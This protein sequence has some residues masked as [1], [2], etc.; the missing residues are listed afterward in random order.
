MWYDKNR[1]KLRYFQ[2]TGHV[3]GKVCSPTCAL[4]ATQRNAQDH[5]DRMPRAAKVVRKSTL[6]DDSLDSMTTWQEARQVILDLIEMHK[7]IGL[8]I[9]KFATNSLKLSESLPEHVQKSEELKFYEQAFGPQQMEYAP[10]TVPKMPQV[11]ALGQF[12]NLATD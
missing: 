5:A 3:F 11:R 2:F 7:A 8:D 4:Y 10:G 12:H 1:K 6:V 9:S